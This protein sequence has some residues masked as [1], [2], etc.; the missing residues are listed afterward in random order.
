MAEEYSEGFFTVIISRTNSD[1]ITGSKI[2]RF[3]FPSPGL[4]PQQV[5]PADLFSVMSYY[6]LRKIMK[7]KYIT[8]FK[9]KYDCV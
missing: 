2:F 7:T 1:Q 6:I 9:D 3:I 5:L 4:L 8:L